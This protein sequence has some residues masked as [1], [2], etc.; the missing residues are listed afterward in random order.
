M[1]QPQLRDIHLP[2]ASLWWPPAPGWWIGLTLILLL[3][4][5]LPRLRRWWR[6][7]PLRRLALGE[8]ARIREIYKQG[9]S[10]KVVLDELARLLRRITISYSGRRQQAASTGAE[11]QAELQRL[12][13]GAEFSREQL[14]LLTHGRYRA[15]FGADIGALLQSSERWMRALPRSKDHVSA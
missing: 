5:L 3:A 6:Q 7:R 2:E 14:E 9:Q 4:L 10:D 12:A 13:P 8:L 11:W 15:E 1:N